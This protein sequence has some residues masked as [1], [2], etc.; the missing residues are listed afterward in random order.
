MNY[1]KIEPNETRTKFKSMDFGQGFLS[2][3]MTSLGS[4]DTN[5]NK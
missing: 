4:T 3:N 1:Q 2:Q 5:I